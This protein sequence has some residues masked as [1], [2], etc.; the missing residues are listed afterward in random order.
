[1]TPVEQAHRKVSDS[2]TM[3]YISLVPDYVTTHAWPLGLYRSRN[4]SGYN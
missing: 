1:M 3:A 2:V 4:T